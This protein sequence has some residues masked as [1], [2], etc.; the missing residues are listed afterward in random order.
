[1]EEQNLSRARS[2]YTDPTLRPPL[3]ESLYSLTGDELAFYQQQ[4]GIDAEDE[5]K[6]HI[7]AVQAKAYDVRGTDFSSDDILGQSLLDLWVPM[8]SNFLVLEVQWI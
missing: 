5:L 6:K 7:L 8:Y 4:T 2:I 3:D 1:M